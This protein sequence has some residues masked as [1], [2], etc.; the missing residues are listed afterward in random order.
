MT[1][2]VRRIVQLLEIEIFH[3][4]VIQIY[5]KCRFIPV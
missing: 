1:Y 5:S 4:I 3:W 2:N